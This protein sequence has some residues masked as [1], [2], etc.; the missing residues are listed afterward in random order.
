MRESKK[1][2]VLLTIIML[3]LQSSIF[4]YT[5]E[6]T[7]ETKITQ[8]F[9][10]V[11]SSNWAYE[12]ISWMVDQKILAGYNDGTFKPAK[13]ISRAEFAKIMVLTLDLPLKNAAEPTFV[14]I[15]KDSWEYEYVETAKYYLTGF[16]TSKGDY[17]K[18]NNEAV[19]EDM[20]V[21]LVK[22]L[23]LTG[24]IVDEK[25]LNAFNDSSS[26][27]P[28]LKKYV[29]I[30]LKNGI[31]KGNPV[32]NSDQKAFRPLNP[33]TRA[34][35]A[36]LLYNIVKEK[37]ITYDDSEPDDENNSKQQEP[38]MSQIETVTAHKKPVVTGKVD[39]SRIMLSWTPADSN[40][41]TYYKVVVSKSNPY[42]R[43]PQDGY[44][45]V[46][47][48]RNKTSQSIDVSNGYNGG[49]FGGK[50]A[51]GQKYYFSVTSIY[52]DEKV[53]GNA[54]Y[55]TVPKKE[56][57]TYKEYSHIKPIV[58]SSVANGKITLKWQP[59]YAS[60]FSYYKVVISKSNSAPKYPEDGYMAYITDKDCTSYTID[61]SKEYSGGD[62]GG[63]LEPGKKYY[64]SVTNVYGSE[65]IAGNALYLEVP[66]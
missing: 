46:I 3:I 59:T 45:F 28:A 10:D 23:K 31:M 1:A 14:D 51:A 64:F 47:S 8:A 62:F 57:E 63:Y 52:S 12:A 38:E 22:A 61:V 65:K 25:V 11:D 37:K 55:L 54:V 50:L 44:M 66:R 15:S 49:D 7:A 40:G 56:T 18:S 13:T 35:A 9:S 42:P 19:R 48:D 43:Y 30:A 60:D 32:E 21:A 26:I 27:S 5:E 33:L 6:N 39:G 53:A 36:V 2:I 20:A 4:V 17:F 24:E 41:F 34:E 29:A 16:R 58:K